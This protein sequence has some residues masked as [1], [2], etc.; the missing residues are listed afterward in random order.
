MNG[1]GRRIFVKQG[2]LALMALGLPPDFLLQPLLAG[3]QGLD[4]KKTLVCIF[5]RGAVDGLSMVVPFGEPGYYDSRRNIA[6]QAPGS[7]G[8]ER[9]GSGRLLRAASGA[10]APRGALPPQRD[11]HRPR[12]RITSP[13][14]FSLR[15][16]GLHGDW[17]ARREV[18]ERRLAQS[19]PTGHGVR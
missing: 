7:G 13:D 18:N 17:N 12:R 9:S 15:R 5:Q 1:I 16:P 4:R 19:G 8:G 3:T 14:P 10:E 6:I 2:A 11:G